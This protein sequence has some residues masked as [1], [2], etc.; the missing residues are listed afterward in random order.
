MKRKEITNSNEKPVVSMG[1]SIQARAKAGQLMTFAT[2]HDMLKQIGLHVGD[3]VK[4]E[5]K[6][7]WV[8]GVA[9]GNIWFHLDGDTGS[10]FWNTMIS[11]T[12]GGKINTAF[13]KKIE[14]IHTSVTEPVVVPTTIYKLLGPEMKSTSDVVLETDVYT[15]KKAIPSH[16]YNGKNNYYTFALHKAI[17]GAN[18]EYFKTLFYGS[19]ATLNPVSIQPVLNQV[20]MDTEEELQY[21]WEFIELVYSETFRTEISLAGLFYVYYYANYFQYGRID[22]VIQKIESKQNTAL[23]KEEVMPLFS[24]GELLGWESYLGTCL[25]KIIENNVPIWFAGEECDPVADEWCLTLKDF[26]KLQ[27]ALLSTYIKSSVKP[28]SQ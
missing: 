28:K 17:L 25:I 5:S 18:C 7:G 6:Q 3:R 24:F 23:T 19:F 13:L 15:M 4:I 16:F 27:L 14:L 1:G 20:K 8:V 9:D 26:P 12:E 21:F 10:S 2:E 11:F 22:K